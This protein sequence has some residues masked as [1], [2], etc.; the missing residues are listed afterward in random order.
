MLE[1]KQR[2]MIEETREQTG[3]KFFVKFQTNFRSKSMQFK[4]N[5]IV[6]FASTRI[7]KTTLNSHFLMNNRGFNWNRIRRPS[8]FIY[9]HLNGS[10]GIVLDLL[11]KNFI[12]GSTFDEQNKW[13]CPKR[14]KQVAIE[15][16]HQIK[17]HFYTT[18]LKLSIQMY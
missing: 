10:T 2:I 8:K 18:I 17:Y 6:H 16:F 4:P 11:F 5:P 14:E 15:R 12:L 9:Q 1:L 7:V 13:L 3:K